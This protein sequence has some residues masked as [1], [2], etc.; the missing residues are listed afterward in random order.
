LDLLFLLLF[1]IFRRLPTAFQRLVVI[2]LVAIGVTMIVVALV[3]HRLSFAVPGAIL[4]LVVGIA[5]LH[6][7]RHPHV[8]YRGL[9][10]WFL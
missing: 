9:I 2:V 5:G 10:G 8:R 4:L 6:L 1:R 3:V 7:R